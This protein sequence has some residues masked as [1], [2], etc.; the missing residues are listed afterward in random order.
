MCKLTLLVLVLAFAGCHEKSASLPPMLYPSAV[1]SLKSDRGWATS[2]VSENSTVAP[3]GERTK[4]SGSLTIE[5]QVRVR[6]CYV[7]RSDCTV[8]NTSPQQWKQGDVYLFTIVQGATTDVVPVL[9]NGQSTNVFEKGLVR[10]EIGNNV[11][12]GL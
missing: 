7:G 11:K 5:N 10:V 2:P 3:T 6:Y 1:I 12:A 8:A 4:Y 9:F